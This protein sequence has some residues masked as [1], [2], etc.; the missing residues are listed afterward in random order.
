MFTSRAEHRLILRQDNADRRLMG[1]GH[2]LGLIPDELS[3]RL[4]RKE[5]LI[6]DGIFFSNHFSITPKD[7]NPILQKVNAELF[8]KTRSLQNC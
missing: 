5:T 3:E 1:L 8:R 2:R 7:A 6:N 4:R